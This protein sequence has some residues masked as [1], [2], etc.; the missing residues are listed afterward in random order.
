MPKR[1]VILVAHPDDEQT[2]ENGW[3]L[4]N[5]RLEFISTNQKILTQCQRAMDAGDEWVYVQRMEYGPHRS[6]VIGRVKVAGVDES[7]MR[8][9]FENWET[10]DAAPCRAFGGSALADFP[11]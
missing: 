7:T 2:Y 8:V 9:R 4:A 11:E 1:L 5:D 3:D 10:Y 6:R